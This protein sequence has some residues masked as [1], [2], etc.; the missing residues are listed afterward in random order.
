MNVYVG[1]T[2]WSWY[3]FLR[4]HDMREVNFWQPSG[5]SFRSL[6]EGELFLFKL[7]ASQGGRIAG[8]GFFVTATT[9]SID[10][11]WRAFG[12]ENGVNNLAQLSD[13][14]WRYK[15]SGGRPDANVN[16]TSIILT[17]VFYFDDADWF[18]IS[19]IWSRYIQTGKTFRGDDA[20]HLVEQVQLRLSGTAAIIAPANLEGSV[21]AAR[22]GFVVGMSKH[23]IGQGGFRTLV[24]DAYH[25]RCAIT[26]ER[27]VPVLQAAH[28]KS[29]A[30]DGPN[31]VNNGILLRS[32]LHAL[33]D[34]G[35]VT[36]EDDL[37]VVVSPRLHDDFGNGK[38]YYPYHGRR[39][40][41]VPDQSILRPAREYLDWHHENVFLG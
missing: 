21:P 34:S 16:I 13:A 3:D 29:F 28:I 31:A 12:T 8:G 17:D 41:V 26:G 22:Q 19:S 9:T 36:I 15:S 38:D 6:Q 33:F 35:Y 4:D 40:A 39:L 30:A 23:R 24:A 27:T 11:A 2:D 18:D 7:K 37:R 25:R 20:A 32:D 5:R 14:I 10:W 1:L